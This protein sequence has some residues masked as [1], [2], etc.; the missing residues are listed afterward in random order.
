MIAPTNEISAPSFVLLFSIYQILKL[1]N[2]PKNRFANKSTGTMVKASG[3]LKY[4][5]F[6][7]SKCAISLLNKEVDRNI[8]P[9]AKTNQ[10][11]SLYKKLAAGAGLRDA[12][13]AGAGNMIRQ[14]N[15]KLL[16]PNIRW[17]VP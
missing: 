7:I 9:Q 3:W 1:K 13:H 8:N 16:L 17:K 10:I 2:I 14:E 15:L 5:A 11:S 6:F 4:S 12:A